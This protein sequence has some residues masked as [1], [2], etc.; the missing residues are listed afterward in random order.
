M[1]GWKCDITGARK[2]DELPVEARRYIEYVENEIHCPMTY[3]SVG[4]GRDE[5]ILRK[6]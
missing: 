4:P 1:P 3:I 5:I 6:A 2:Y